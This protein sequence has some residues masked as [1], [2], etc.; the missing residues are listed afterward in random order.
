MRSM[1]HRSLALDFASQGYGVPQ[2]ELKHRLPAD[3]AAQGTRRAM[4]DLVGTGQ[5]KAH[6][7]GNVLLVVVGEAGD[8]AHRKIDGRK[9]MDS[10]LV[11]AEVQRDWTTIAAKRKTLASR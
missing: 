1:L 4:L 2:I 11:H 6:Q 7:G 8:L 10:D 5:S 9:N 3:V